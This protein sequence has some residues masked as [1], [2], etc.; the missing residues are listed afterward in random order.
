MSFVH[1]ANSL[2][3]FFLLCKNI[4]FLTPDFAT[5]KFRGGGAV[6]PGWM[7]LPKKLW[8]VEPKL[9]SFLS[10]SFSSHALFPPF[11]IDVDI[12][13]C[14]GQIHLAVVPTAIM[15]HARGHILDCGAHILFLG[16]HQNLHSFSFSD[17]TC[18][19]RIRSSAEACFLL[20]MAKLG[21]CSRNTHA[22][23]ESN[24]LLPLCCASTNLAVVWLETA[25]YP[26]DQRQQFPW[27]G[28][29]VCR[30]STLSHC[31]VTP[32][33]NLSYK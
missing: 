27:S 26:R 2:M 23:Q 16:A 7:N 1:I 17:N 31:T 3:T 22:H 21:H 18:F 10:F 8:E 11:I 24:S 28:A 5:Q 6:V 4:N 32:A 13:M 14:E 25:C 9:L 33:R 19:P 15:I 12:M 29:A 30:T 20:M